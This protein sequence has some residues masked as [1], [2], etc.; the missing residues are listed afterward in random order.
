M[1]AAD[2][3]DGMD[4]YY[5]TMIIQYDTI[6]YNIVYFRHRTKITLQQFVLKIGVNGKGVDIII[7]LLW[8]TPDID[9]LSM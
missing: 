5:E 2:N 9:P 6:R 1:T 3:M 7:I 8:S 4:K